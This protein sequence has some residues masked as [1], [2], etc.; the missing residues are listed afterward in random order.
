[1][2]MEKIKTFLGLRSLE[3]NNANNY[4]ENPKNQTWIRKMTLDDIVDIQYSVSN[5]LRNRQSRQSCQSH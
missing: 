2:E 5:S 1:M 4:A 3:N